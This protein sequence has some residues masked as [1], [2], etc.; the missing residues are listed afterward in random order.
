MAELRPD[1][2]ACF[3]CRDR[4]R[5]PVAR[6][7]SGWALN[8]E[9]VSGMSAVTGTPHKKTR[10]AWEMFGGRRVPADQSVGVCTQGWSCST[11]STTAVAPAR[12]RLEVA[13]IE[14]ARRRHSRNGVIE[15]SMNGIVPTRDGQPAEAAACGRASI[16]PTARHRGWRCRGRRHLLVRGLIHMMVWP[17]PGGPTI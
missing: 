17:R 15:Y 1:V 9:Q 2:I 12:P 8:I 16:R 14:S 6:L 10:S 4:P 5:R 7:S 13:Q 11:R 3:A